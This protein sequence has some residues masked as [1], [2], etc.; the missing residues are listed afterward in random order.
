MLLIVFATMGCQQNEVPSDV[1]NQEIEESTPIV[2]EEKD[3]KEDL[4]NTNEIVEENEEAI[5]KT[6]DDETI[7]DEGKVNQSNILSEEEALKV[8][9]TAWKS[10]DDFYENSVERSDGF[11]DPP[12]GIKNPQDLAEYFKEYMSKEMAIDLAD[13]LL[14]DFFE[15]GT[16]ILR[17]TEQIETVHWGVSDVEVVS[18]T[19]DK[20]VVSEFYDDE[21]L[22]TF[23]KISHLSLIDGKWILSKVE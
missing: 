20:I 23:E 7:V 22:G 4:P 21:Y 17:P 11:M 19:E 6:N 10:L 13:F 8:F 12:E 18:I 3:N 5:E 9:M 16:Y 14:M 1:P 15:D 2:E